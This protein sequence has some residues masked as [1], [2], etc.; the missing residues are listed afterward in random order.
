MTSEFYS[1]RMRS[2]RDEKHIS[3][4]EGVLPFTQLEEAASAMLLRALNHPRGSA[5]K[6]NIRLEQINQQKIRKEALL[7]FST[8]EVVDW[9]SGRKYAC[10][11]LGKIGLNPRIV[12]DSMAQLAA[13]PSP[14]GGAM[15]G[16]MLINS[17]TGQRLERDLTRGVRVSRM[18]LDPAERERI[19]SIL[20]K[21]SL[22][23]S[24][25]IEAWTL[26]S[27]VALYPQIMAE[28]CWSDDPDYLT[29]YV[30]SAKN[31]YQRITRL[32]EAGCHIGGRIFFIKPESDLSTLIERLQCEPVL[33]QA[34]M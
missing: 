14:Q 18:D 30:A 17:L 29:G 19:T 4:A 20:D 26:A 6:I 7:P 28:L 3:G 23:N 1:L 10:A 5:E 15:R 21:K 16:A 13:G 22:A 33:F 34:P 9:Q 32:K 24:R 27:K 11:L 12:H 31:G 8:H 2:C 25:V